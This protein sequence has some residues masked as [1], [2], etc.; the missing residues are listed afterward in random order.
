MNMNK[1]WKQI[2]VIILIIMLNLNNNFLVVFANDNEVDTDNM[3][4]FE[5]SIEK[6]AKI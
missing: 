4:E 5:L 1:I 3:I 2:I 6:Y